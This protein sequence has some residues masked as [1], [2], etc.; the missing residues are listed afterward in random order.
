[1]M[2][3][4]LKPTEKRLVGYAV[5]LAVRVLDNIKS[6]RQ[7]VTRVVIHQGTLV[8]HHKYATQTTYT[9]TSKSD[10]EQ[11]LYLDHP[12]PSG[13]WE[14]FDTPTPH[15]ITENY[16]RF[17]LALPPNKTTKFVV[18]MQYPQFERFA[19]GNISDAIL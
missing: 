1:A 5:E 14:L 15:E 4:T 10:K 17:K 19:L 11:T 12:R 7:R 2:L 18:K 16:W 3:D 9:F 8:A 13:E 6:F